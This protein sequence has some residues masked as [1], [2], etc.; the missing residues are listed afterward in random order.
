MRAAE[1]GKMT[2][3]QE[4]ERAGF[5]QMRHA[6]AVMVVAMARPAAVAGKEGEPIHCGQRLIDAGVFSPE[7]YFESNADLAAQ[8]LNPV[9]HCLRY[10]NAEGLQPI[11][12]E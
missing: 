7:W 4:Q 8:G 11:R 2:G 5:A 9:L 1:L 6:A 12:P 3:L 10:G